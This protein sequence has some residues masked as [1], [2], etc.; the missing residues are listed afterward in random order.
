MRQ[1]LW[2][3]ALAGL[4]FGSLSM[5]GGTAIGG[6]IGPLAIGCFA[7]LSTGGAGKRLPLRGTAGAIGAFAISD[8]PHMGQATSPLACCDS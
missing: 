5:V 1:S 8:E 6:E 2:S 4:A 3:V 7:A